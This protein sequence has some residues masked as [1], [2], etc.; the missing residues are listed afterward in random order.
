MNV[1]YARMSN[2]SQTCRLSGCRMG[3]RQANHDARKDEVVIPN[4]IETQRKLIRVKRIREIIMRYPRRG[5]DRLSFHKPMSGRAAPV[6][7]SYVHQ[8][9]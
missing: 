2:R 3:R 9:H 8:A 6:A 5:A 4:D 7:S 1:R